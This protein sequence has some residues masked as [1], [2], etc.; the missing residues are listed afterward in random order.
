MATMNT[1][2]WTT[3]RQTEMYRFFSVAF[4]A[5]PGTTY[6]DQ[7]YDAVISG[8]STKEIVNVFVTKSEFTSV[9]PRS[10]PNATFATKI[11]D[12]VVGSSATA[13]AKAQA[14]ADITAAL[15][16]G[17]SRG[18]IV[19]QIFTN[20]ATK[21]ATDADWAGTS[22]QMANQ[23]AVARYYTETLNKGGTDLTTLQKV[24]AGVTATTDT[25]SVAALAAVIDTALPPASQS[26]N[27]TAGTDSFTGG[28]GADT[29]TAGV[30][31]SWS[32]G[33]A[34]DGG[35]GSDT[36]L[37][38][39]TAAIAAPAGA[40]VKNIESATVSSGGAV[41]LDTTAWSGLLSLSTTGVNSASSAITAAATTNVSASASTVG[42]TSLTVNGGKD[43]AVTATGMDNG[44]SITVGNA[45]APVGGVT[46][47]STGTVAG[48]TTS[49]ALGGVT[50]TGGT[51]VSVTESA[52]L[53][54]AIV[55][56]AKTATN[57]GTVTLG[58]VSVT[59]SALTS[60]VSVTQEGQKAVN[61]GTTANQMGITPGAVTITDANAASATA[62]GTI[63]SVTLDKYGNST[64]NS[65][66]LN[67]VTL[68]GSTTTGLNT[69]TGG[70]LNIERGALT[71]VP[72]AN[73]LTLNVKGG[74][75]GTITDKEAE[76]GGQNDD[77]FT[78][79]NINTSTASTTI[80]DLAA[81]DARTLTIAGDKNLTFTSATLLANVTS[82][83]VTN[84]GATVF[85]SQLKTDATFTGGAGAESIIIQNATKAI[86]LG[87][88]N[89]TV[90]LA[91]STVLSSITGTVD[92]GEG[93]DT[94]TAPATI[95]ASASSSAS[96]SKL[97]NFERLA[98][99]NDN[100]SATVNLASFGA[101]NYIS[102][103][104][105][106]SLT[107]NNAAANPTLIQTGTG[108]IT[109]NLA[110]NTGTS[111]SL[112]YKGA[113]SSGTN[114]GTL[115]APGVES[116]SVESDDS[117]TTTPTGINHT[118]V[119]SNSALKTLT[120][121]GDA[122]L[123]LTAASTAIT[124]VDA[125]AMSRQTNSGGTSIT[126]VSLTLGALA[127]AATITGGEGNDSFDATSAT[128]AL[129][130]EG[131]GGTDTLYGGAGADTITDSSAANVN[132]RT[133]ASTAAGNH[134]YG[135]GGADTIT[136]GAAA[137]TIGG[138]S[139]NDWI[140]A[141]A[142]NDTVYGGTTAGTLTDSTTDGNDYVDGGDGAD[143]IVSAGGNDTILGGTGNDVITTSSGA[144][145]ILGGD[146]DDLITGGSGNDIITGDTGADT[147]VAGTGSDNVSGGEGNDTLSFTTDG[148]TSA[149]TVA[150]G[151]GTDTL[152]LTATGTALGNADFTNVTGIEQIASFTGV[153]IAA[154][155]GDK[156]L[157]I[158]SI[159]T[160]TA[161][162]SIA[163]AATYTTASLSINLS[164]NAGGAD[165]I[166]GSLSATS[167]SITATAAALSGPDTLIG[168]TGANDTL[169]IAVSTDAATA[170]L[171]ATSGIETITVVS[172]GT[173]SVTL[174]GL[175]PAVGK[176]VTVNAA[177]FT[178]PSATV[179][180]TSGSGGG[181]INITG[182]SGND[183]ISFA[184]SSGNNIAVGGAGD[185]V[186]TAGS[187]IDNLS[188]GDGADR[189]VVAA[190]NF[191]AADTFAGGA[192]ADILEISSASLS[193]S[194][195]VLDANFANV[196]SVATLRNAN[197]GDTSAFTLDLSA[198][199]A[200]ITT[201][202]RQGTTAVATGGVSTTDDTI[203]FGANYTGSATVFLGKGDDYVNGTSTTATLAIHMAE[204]PNGS[205]T[206]VGGTGASDSL[207]IGGDSGAVVM[208]SGATARI[209]GIESITLVD[210]F[211]AQGGNAGWSMTTVDA[212]VA[213]GKTLSVALASLPVT[214]TVVNPVAGLD[215]NS[216]T[217]TLSFDGS[218][219]TNGAFIITGGDYNDT[220]IGGQGADTIIGGSGR[221]SITGGLGADVI[222]L[223]SSTGA[224]DTV[225]DT[226][227]YL[228]AGFET[229]TLPPTAVYYGGVVASGTVVSTAGLDKVYG[230]AADSTAGSQ[231]LS[232]VILTPF[233][234]GSSLSTNGVGKAWTA[235]NGYLRGTYDATAQ[236][237][238]MS[239]TGTDSLYAFDF[240]GSDSTSDLRAIV[241]VGYVD[242]LGNDSY[243]SGLIG[244]G[245]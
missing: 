240:D 8:M 87:A 40:S 140:V 35:A 110:D 238:T 172:S 64:V 155:L 65:S 201:V 163:L 233:G 220:I 212:N 184:N 15:T 94:V 156:A 22:K 211:Q 215:V 166:D 203:T 236:T 216:D 3:E 126:G 103:A 191:T 5:A 202:G 6:M 145:S 68:T 153:A 60:S 148:L 30:A 147:I 142:G 71:A 192:G 119:I 108:S 193:N 51:S 168:G 47:S 67:T 177:S 24:V 141:G 93:D 164:T 112:S 138:G 219:E 52:G 229:G 14:A 158:T 207:T 105:S 173:N 224:A 123:V 115:S 91:A 241:L 167:L 139:G 62:A 58:S 56:A 182:G 23:V 117:V 18:D 125:S 106:A 245:G 169:T 19:Y 200:G 218:A 70:T 48:Q 39:Q 121:K 190:A 98:I 217:V 107:L 78:T 90:T 154:T 206:I 188:G 77:G 73:T 223:G 176:S 27:L 232:D 244:V 74:L 189:F 160:S 239:A 31:S 130:M 57:N 174:S 165:S 81:D 85:G 197:A 113:A 66:A 43:V 226:L 127:G 21:P 12:A 25:T 131:N 86:S 228:G 149:D 133:G 118:L 61:S 180:F 1:A 234:G 150:G 231:T 122:G 161:A 187:G 101:I 152:F 194:S 186:L 97:T 32:P 69:D 181:V 102:S 7:L 11:V 9:Y 49:V 222:Y 63:T 75:I 199:A 178:N 210:R 28:A 100:A 55:N 53:T 36:L 99:S 208:N 41:N 195:P 42:S 157:G 151:D 175:A 124:S 162:D 114:L 33:D 13:A 221:D 44:G 132:P 76:A 204:R 243:S 109:V 171:S 17:W 214:T 79:I 198:L 183:T 80:N 120:L 59:G 227:V 4:N 225:S 96:L 38:S 54:S 37:I 46:V 89:D 213:S 185:D 135:G 137:D 242:T 237:F 179:A 50:V 230:F 82:V 20:L 196:S 10:M 209:S 136:G 146:G 34:L 104:S 159:E 26:F 170:D 2:L 235:L 84:T 129:R 144:N 45:V 29:F 88:G 111:D 143:S 134:L 128:A 83:T 95:A 116:M 72:S 92:G 16:A 205:D